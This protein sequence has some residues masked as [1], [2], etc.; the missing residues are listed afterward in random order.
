LPAG[1][2]GTMPARSQGRLAPKR[3]AP[4]RSA[5]KRSAPK[6]QA[7]AACSAELPRGVRYR[8]DKDLY[9]IEDADWKHVASCRTR[10]EAVSA[11]IVLRGLCESGVPTA[12]CGLGLALCVCR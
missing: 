2:P 10:A 4:K 9:I 5:P 3:L 7:K 11:Q 1:F 12:F 8:A 6:R